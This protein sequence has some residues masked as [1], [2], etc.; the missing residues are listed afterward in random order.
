MALGRDSKQRDLRAFV[1]VWSVDMFLTHTSCPLHVPLGH[2]NWSGVLFLFVWVLHSP[3]VNT[4]D[5]IHPSLPG[6]TGLYALCEANSHYQVRAGGQGPF[7]PTIGTTHSLHCSCSWAACTRS[8]PWLC[9]CLIFFLLFYLPGYLCLQTRTE[10]LM[11]QGYA[12]G[13]ATH[14]VVAQYAA[15]L[16]WS[17]V[18]MI[19]AVE[20]H[21]SSSPS[22]LV[23]ALVLAGS[24]PK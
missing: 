24:L 13:T 15:C 19:L 1:S 5:T 20:G 4:T 23:P 10:V 17:S 21:L 9:S 2:N 8:I 14:S 7:P 18:C 12:L 11:A 3:L 16:H 6:A 22:P